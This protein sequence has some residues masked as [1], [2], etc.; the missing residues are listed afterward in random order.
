MKAITL[1]DL[2]I[3]IDEGV[4]LRLRDEDGMSVGFVRLPA[5]ARTCVLPP[6]AFPAISAP[7]RTGVT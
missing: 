4:Q 3:V 6:R 5:G 2:P 1:A 7:V